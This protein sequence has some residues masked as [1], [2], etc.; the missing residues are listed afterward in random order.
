MNVTVVKGA[1]AIIKM[2]EN[3]ESRQK[4]LQE[5]VDTAKKAID[6]FDFDDSIGSSA[7]HIACDIIQTPLY[8]QCRKNCTIKA[9]DLDECYAAFNEICEYANTKTVFTPTINTFCRFMNICTDTLKSIA[10]ENNER[11]QIAKMII[12]HLGD[13]LMQN[14]LSG[15]TAPIPSMFVAKAN[16]GMKENESNTI[17]IL[18]VN[19]T[20]RDVDDI[21][22]EFKV[23]TTSK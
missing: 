22:R 6:E 21:L 12:E 10:R 5:S 23:A 8:Y 16:F 18:N 11:G 4:Y 2:E 19:E 3:A 7:A 17:N 1:R 9:V 13:R 15:T 20:P 14:M